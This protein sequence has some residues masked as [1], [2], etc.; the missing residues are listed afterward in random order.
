MRLCARLSH[1][2]QAPA[3]PRSQRAATSRQAHSGPQLQSAP[4]PAPLPE[5]TCPLAC[6][7]HSGQDTKPSSQTHQLLLSWSPRVSADNT[8]AQT[9]QLCTAPAPVAPALSPSGT[10]TPAHS[11]WPTCLDA[12]SSVG[13]G[14]RARLPPGSTEGHMGVAVG[15]QPGCRWRLACQRAWGGDQ[16]GA[17]GQPW[18]RALTVG[19]RPGTERS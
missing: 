11:L 1:V 8:P 16:A 19:P 2:A 18:G 4:P 7:T 9:A 15:P 3:A 10:P 5:D 12:S 13:S 14:G 6:S 17:W